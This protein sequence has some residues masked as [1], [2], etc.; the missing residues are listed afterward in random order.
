[1]GKILVVDDEPKSVKL[2]RM[3][4]E[5]SGH[6]V[7]AAADFVEASKKLEVELFDVLITDVRLPDRSGIELVKLAKT[8]QPAVSAV[9]ITAYGTIRDAVKAMTYGAAEYIQK[10][11]EL[12]ALGMLVER[13]LESARIRAEHSYLIDQ[14]LEGASEVLLVGRSAAMQKVRELVDK[15]APTHSN[16]LIQGES[17]TGKELVALAIH[18]RSV[19]NTQPLIKV[20]CPGIPSSLFESELF[21]HMKGSFTGAYESRKGKFELAGKGDILLDEISEIPLELQ[22]KLLRVLEDRHF[23]RIGGST[24]VPVEARIIAATNKDLKKL[25]ETGRFRDDLYYRLNVFPIHLSPLRIRKEDIAEIAFH[26]LPRIA[27][28]CGLVADGITEAAVSAIL[29]YDW[30]G[31]VRE[32]RNVLER[33]LVLAGGGV[34]DLD[35]LPVEIQEGCNSEGMESGKFVEKVDGYKKEL[36]LEALREVNWRK[37]DAARNLGLTQRA[38]SHY[39]QKYDLDNYRNT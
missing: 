38:F 1:M 18:S 25:V 32:L 11:F 33:G 2:I 29:H 21:G 17:G 23:T 26:L 13:L 30:P 6:T 27:R 12:E 14:F 31:N 16:I 8:Q 20:N 37:K 39:V 28:S 36:L 35:H 7:V 22:S 19:S 4:F 10:P 15:V 9:V 5:E 3:R 34:V 24:D